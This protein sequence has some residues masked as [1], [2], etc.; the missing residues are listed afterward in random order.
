MNLSEKF[1][2]AL[3]QPDALIALRELVIMLRSEG[4]DKPTIAAELQQLRSQV[5]Q[6]QGD[7]IL[8]VLDFLN[9]WCS[10]HMKID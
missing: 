2:Q 8:E 1:Q 7:I 5:D 3:D 9:G 6:F 4:M 10:P